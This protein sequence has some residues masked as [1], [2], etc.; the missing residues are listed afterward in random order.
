MDA[1]I[2]GILGISL[3][4]TIQFVSILGNPLLVNELYMQELLKDQKKKMKPL[5]KQSFLLVV[6]IACLK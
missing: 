4:L 3:L 1:L 2:S 6:E 5:T